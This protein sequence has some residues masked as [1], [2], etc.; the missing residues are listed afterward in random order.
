MNVWETTQFLVRSSPLNVILIFFLFLP[1]PSPVTCSF[2]TE[3]VKRG[4]RKNDPQKLAHLLLLVT[5]AAVGK[6]CCALGQPAASESLC[7][8]DEVMILGARR[9]TMKNPGMFSFHEAAAA[10]G[11]RSSLIARWLLKIIQPCPFST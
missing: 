1:H 2:N 11:A 8:Y 3:G 5:A 6:C 9:R 4:E 7:V 10:A